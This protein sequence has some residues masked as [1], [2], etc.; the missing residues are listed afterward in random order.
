MQHGVVVLDDAEAYEVA[1]RANYG[2]GGS[3]AAAAAVVV[4]VVMVVVVVDM[5]PRA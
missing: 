3:A 5:M 1:V 2:L 4:V